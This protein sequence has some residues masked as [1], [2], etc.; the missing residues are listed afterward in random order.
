ML[1]NTCRLRVQL[2]GRRFS[3]ESGDDLLLAH[4][5]QT[6]LSKACSSHSCPANGLQ[7]LQEKPGIL[8]QR[9]QV[10]CPPPALHPHSPPGKRSQ[11]CSMPVLTPG[12]YSCSPQR[13]R[14]AAP[15]LV[16]SSH[17]TSW[18]NFQL[19]RDISPDSS[20]CDS[21][22]TGYTTHSGLFKSHFGFLS[23]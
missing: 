18:L 16:K 13:P 7:W 6:N 20:T 5:R 22:T 1:G 10:P 11:G 9:V 19:L 21:W 15:T 8:V 2:W 17:P 3:K 14:T 12:G 23:H 4:R